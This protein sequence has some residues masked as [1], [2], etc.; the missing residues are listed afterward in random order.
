MTRG[1]NEKYKARFKTGLKEGLLDGIMVEIDSR[2]VSEI[3]FGE[4]YKFLG[5]RYGLY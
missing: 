3:S 4:M 2:I 1:L 5:K